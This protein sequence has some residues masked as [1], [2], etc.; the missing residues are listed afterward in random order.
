M[1]KTQVRLQQ[2]SQALPNFGVRDGKD[3]FDVYPPVYSGTYMWSKENYVKRIRSVLD[4]SAEEA[5]GKGIPD[6]GFTAD[7]LLKK[8]GRG[9]KNYILEALRRLIKEGSVEPPGNYRLR[10]RWTVV[11]SR[12][13]QL[14]A[15]AK[16]NYP[17]FRGPRRGF[18]RQG[19]KV[20][21][22]NRLGHG[23]RQIRKIREREG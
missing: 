1:T 15:G 23:E 6:R 4:A 21:Q 18:A 16:W 13:Y 12:E 11:N 17:T 8:L 19:P 9:S 22:H 7:E 20:T 3:K 2:S 14:V 5:M 10:V